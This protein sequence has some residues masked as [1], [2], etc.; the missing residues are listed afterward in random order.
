M[1]RRGFLASLSLIPFVK[2]PK[3]EF[4]LG[5]HAQEIL[6]EGIKFF[7]PDHEIGIE[8]FIGSYF[9]QEY[10]INMNIGPIGKDI[11]IHNH[12]ITLNYS[13]YYRPTGFSVYAIQYNDYNKSILFSVADWYDNLFKSDFTDPNQSR[14][15]QK[16]SIEEMRYIGKYLYDNY[17]EKS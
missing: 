3:P 6:Q 15:D 4:K 11:C 10:F 5:Q 1:I 17:T 13:C 12:S 2:L 16:I 9:P 7:E 14:L 8:T